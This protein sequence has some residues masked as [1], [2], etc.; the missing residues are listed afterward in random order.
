M[1]YLISDDGYRDSVDL[2]YYCVTEQDIKNYVEFYYRTMYNDKVRNI[3]VNF[4]EKIINFES[5]YHIDE[6]WEDH[7]MYLHELNKY[8]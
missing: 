3:E 1:I 6:D 5:S 8:E 7:I 4:E 2:E